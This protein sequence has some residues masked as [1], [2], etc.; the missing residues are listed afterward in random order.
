METRLLEQAHVPRRHV[1]SRPP[2]FTSMLRSENFGLGPRVRRVE[3]ALDHQQRRVRRH[4]RAAYTQDLDAPPGPPSRGRSTSARRR[5]RLPA[6]IR[7]SCRRQS[8]PGP[9]LARAPRPP[10]RRRAAGRR[11]RRARSGG[12]R[13]SPRAAC[14]CRRRRRRSSRSG[15]SR[16]P[17]SHRAV[18]CAGEVHAIAPSYA[19]LLL[20]G[21]T[22]LATPRSKH[23]RA[24][25]GMRSHRSVRTLR[26][27]VRAQLPQN[28]GCRRRIEAPAGQWSQRYPWRSSSPSSV[29]D[30]ASPH[31]SIVA[32]MSMLASARSRR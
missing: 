23:R 25:G 20:A 29:S 30:E 10:L 19:E 32:R 31:R 28:A 18:R 16:T 22:L 4:G 14:R 24:R 27:Q 15:R 7:R 5:R 9:R 17:S 21:M 3:V 13:G 1:R 26:Q 8:G 11:G 12:R 2:G 6:P